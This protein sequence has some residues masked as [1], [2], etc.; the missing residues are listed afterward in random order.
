MRR[1]VGSARGGLAKG[2]EEGGFKAAFE[3]EIVAEI[4]TLVGAGAVDDWDFEAIETA[5]RRFRQVAH[6]TKAG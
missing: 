5:A 3:A 1:P 4:K 2:G 6:E